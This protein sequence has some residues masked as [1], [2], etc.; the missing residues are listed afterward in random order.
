MNAVELDAVEEY[1]VICFKSVLGGIGYGGN[2]AAQETAVRNLYRALKPGGEPDGHTS[3]SAPPQEVQPLEYLALY[4]HKGGSR[5]L[6]RFFRGA[7]AL[8][9]LSR[10]LR[11]ERGTAARPGPD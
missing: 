3:S 1:D 2:K 7:L 9:R 10:N 4:H 8:L 11:Q 6:F 5:L